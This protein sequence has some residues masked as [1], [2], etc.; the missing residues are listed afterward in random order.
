MAGL[1]N[2]CTLGPFQPRPFRVRARGRGWNWEQFR[3]F[4]AQAVPVL[5][6]SLWK[7]L[8]LAAV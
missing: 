7:E 3:S 2:G 6:P 4:P 1:G 5:I 8:E